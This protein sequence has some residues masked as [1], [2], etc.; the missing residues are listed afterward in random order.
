MFLQILFF[1]QQFPDMRRIAGKQSVFIFRPGEQ[2]RI[3]GNMNL[4]SAAVAGFVPGP[5]RNILIRDFRQSSVVIQHMIKILQG[6]AAGKKLLRSKFAEQRHETGIPDP[7]IGIAESLIHIRILR[8]TGN[9]PDMI[10]SQFPG[11]PVK[12]GKFRMFITNRLRQTVPDF[13]KRLFH[14]FCTSKKFSC[15]TITLVAEI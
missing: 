13:S 2:R 14:I 7:D 15:H 4:N 9:M 11:S 5:F 10:V 12:F 8:H 3:V 6:A 1:E